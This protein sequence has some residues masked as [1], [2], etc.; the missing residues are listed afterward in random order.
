M[1]TKEPIYSIKSRN[2]AKNR[3][4]KSFNKHLKIDNSLPTATCKE[5]RAPSPHCIRGLVESSLGIC[6]FQE[7]TNYF[8]IRGHSHYSMH[9]FFAVP[10]LR[11]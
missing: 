3:L 4:S 6:K 5:K 11:I 2:T 10:W 8:A 7:N 9:G 1:N